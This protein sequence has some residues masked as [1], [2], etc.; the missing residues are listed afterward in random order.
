MT[1]SLR[2]RV[3]GLLHIQKERRLPRRGRKPA[4]GDYVVCGDLRITVQAG[5]TDDLWEW[6]ME[7]GWRELTYRPE[8]RNYREV[9]VSWVTRLI[10]AA[11]AERPAL[12][13]AAV[14]RASLRPSLGDPT[15]MPRYI[16][17]H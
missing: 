17:R 16:E 15:A 14:A 10:D 13:R 2:G 4:I 5:F 11:P 7:Q 6:L 12:L 8:R 9:P 1:L 3:R